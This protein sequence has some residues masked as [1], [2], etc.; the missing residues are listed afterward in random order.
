MTEIRRSNV[1]LAVALLAVAAGG[2]P[3]LRRRPGQ[4]A[5][6]EDDVERGEMTP[7][8]LLEQGVKLLQRGDRDL[9]FGVIAESLRLEPLGA[10][11]LLDDP[12]FADL[13][14]YDDMRRFRTTLQQE[15]ARIADVGY[16]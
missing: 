6:V 2:R 7:A 12:A 10:L 1:G 5:E 16:A 3:W 8:E 13:L 9:G 15:Q 14:E 11:R 4:A